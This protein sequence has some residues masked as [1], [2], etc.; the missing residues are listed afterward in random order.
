MEEALRLGADVVGGHLSI[1]TDF[2]EH[3]QILFD[4]AEQFDRDLDI[5]VD[6]DIDR[7]YSRQTI[8]AD[9]IKYPDA[10]GVVVLA[11][12]TIRRGFVGRVSAGHLCGLDSISPPVSDKVMDLIAS[13]G[14]K[15]CSLASKQP[16]LSGSIQ[17]RKMFAGELR[18]LSRCCNMVFGLCLGVTT[19]VIHSIR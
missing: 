8:H 12:E 19:S 13:A 6:Y 1:A 5:H 14:F 16:V 9:G 17:T 10:L 2:R 7:D 15:D 3:T 11:E 18:K 4:L